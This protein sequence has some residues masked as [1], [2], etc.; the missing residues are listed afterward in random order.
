MSADVTTPCKSIKSGGGLLNS[1]I[2]ALPFELHIPGYQFCGPGTR[3]SERLARDDQGINPLDA[4][5][6]EHDIAYSHSNDLAE[7]HVADK[8]LAQKARKR[9]IARN[10]TLGERAAAA[11]VWEAMKVKTKI[12]MGMKM[13]MKK[14]TKRVHT[15]VKRGDILP[16]L[17]MLG[18]L[19]SLIGGAAGVAMA[20]SN[21][22][23]TRRQLEEL[24]HHN[25]ALEGHG[26][27]LAAY[28]YG[29]G[30]HL[31]PYKR[32]QGVITKK[33]KKR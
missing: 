9:I 30:L 15:A 2:N 14:K 26:L 5:C 6:R 18:A 29:K 22:K 11:A 23:A 21:S 13:K 19:G 28:K 8:L 4:A 25:R 3:L 24:K 10:S 31:G 17:P 20:V 33:K 32:G 27:Y 16:S 12:G 1:V 7:R